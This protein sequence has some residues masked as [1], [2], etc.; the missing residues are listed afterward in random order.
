MIQTVFQALTADLNQIQQSIQGV[1]ATLIDV[2]KA[3]QAGFADINFQTG[4]IRPA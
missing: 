1:E 2:F 4:A 3:M